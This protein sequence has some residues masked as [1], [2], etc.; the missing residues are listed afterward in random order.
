MVSMGSFR[1]C[2]GCALALL[3]LSVQPAEARDKTDTLTLKNGDRITGEIVKLE[4]GKLQFKTDDMGTLNVEWPA[5]TKLTSSFTFDVEVVTG[6][7]YLGAIKASEDGRRLVVMQ[8][9][10]LVEL[11]PLTV[12][13]IAEVDQTFWGRVNGSLSLGYNFT[14]SSD[15][16]IVSTH[17]DASYRAA[18]V[19]MGLNIDV[20]STTS[21]EQG[22]LDRDQI[23]FNY[24]WL[25]PK[26][27]FWAGLLSL[28]RNEE[29]GIEGRLQ[30][31]GSLGHYFRQT[32]F[33]EVTG[34]IGVVA[35]Q[36]WVTGTEGG[37]QSAEGLLA[38]S[39]RLYRF[40]TPE[41]SL[42]SSA[43]LYPGI[44]ESGRYR[45]NVDVTLRREIIEDFFIDLSVYYDYD[46]Q[47]PGDDPAKDDYGVVTSIGYS[48]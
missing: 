38:G 35:N 5:V 6:Q 36:E 13:R 25:R 40:S 47:P 17:L 10:E 29:L 11:D 43:A 32:S 30:A 3:A 15:I 23:N 14:K 39:W 18:T 9:P 42:T 1:G 48:F 27:N 28:E 8:T 34:S 16:K 4:Y 26:R 41:T 12:S 45:A 2:I 31:G 20:T 22:T 33:S 24:Q 44:T 7:R 37:Q 46:N 21:P 19:A